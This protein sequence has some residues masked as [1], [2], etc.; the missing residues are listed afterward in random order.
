[1]LVHRENT[2]RVANWAVLSTEGRW[3][4]GEMPQDLR[5]AFKK[6]A[7]TK[8]KEERKK[9]AAARVEALSDK[10]KAKRDAG[11]LQ[12][13]EIREAR[14]A[15]DAAELKQ[16]QVAAKAEREKAAAA[17][18][19]KVLASQ[20]ALKRQLEEA[21][22]STAPPTK[23]QRAR[24]ASSAP[25]RPPKPAEYIPTLADLRLSPFQQRPMPAL[26]T[27]SC[28]LQCCVVYADA[29]GL[30]AWGDGAGTWAHPSGWL[31]L[32]ER[33]NQVYSTPGSEPDWCDEVINGEY[34]VV[35]VGKSDHTGDVAYL[36]PI[37]DREGG[38]VPLGNVV[39]RVTRPDSDHMEEGQ[40]KFHRYKRLENLQREV[41]FTLHGAV[42]GFAP[43]CYAA[44]LFPAVVVKTKDGPVQ[45]Y[46]TLYIMRRAQVDLGTALDDHVEQTN[47]R[48]NPQSME[49]VDSLRK[50]G[51]R[52]ATRMLSV[53]VRQSRLGVLSFDAKPGNYVFGKD[54]EPYAIDFDAAMYAVDAAPRNWEPNL[55]M[56][57]TLLTAHVR[58]YRHPALADGW[59]SAVRELM[60][61]LCTHSRGELWL[62][63]ARVDPNRKFREMT[64][65]SAE[66]QRK[67]L[68]MVAKAYFVTPRGQVVTPFR[69]VASKASSP[70]LH[71]LVRY[72]L[73][74]SIKRT[75]GPLDRA[76]GN[77]NAFCVGM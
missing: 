77:P 60:I 56:N 8:K 15:K 7:E 74:G 57:L 71:Q 46:G 41:Y 55:L 70:L 4:R 21:S 44:L 58:C 26:S 43:E 53:I 36:P 5:V 18:K 68:E 10:Q 37:K 9:L 69:G 47:G 67:C 28:A 31:K 72:C 12:R 1:M 16:R 22:K 13:K 29:Q 27:L 39:F 17:E 50:S 54:N 42:N 61:E 2:V 3:R 49:Y 73:H 23:M 38:T 59:A 30:S 45:L 14:L 25:T 76:L 75:D 48:V 40:G 35:F 32:I 11:I 66:T 24:A 52:V 20:A 34:N 51:R 65:N 62:Q 64:I 63:Q 6:R 33:F 19:Q